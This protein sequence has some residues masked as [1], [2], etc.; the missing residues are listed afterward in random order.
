MEGTSELV[1]RTGNV[2]FS[3]VVMGKLRH[4]VDLLAAIKELAR[5]EGIHAGVI[6]S[7]LGALSEAVFRNLRVMPDD[8]KIRNEHRLFI[9]M[10]QSL[11]LVSLT[12]WIA[13]KEDG[14]L[15]IH[16]HFGTSAVVGDEIVMLGGHLTEG[17][18]T[19][20]KAV[21]TIG[22]IDDP[23]V[24]SRMDPQINQT[25]IFFELGRQS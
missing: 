6:L 12:G 1:E 10:K 24:R 9:H 16:A 20:V 11:E 15:D 4:G 17:T 22:V 18:I 7:G 2:Q 19:S 3:R 8:F 25:E 14:E 23:K 13:Q 21:V 5:V